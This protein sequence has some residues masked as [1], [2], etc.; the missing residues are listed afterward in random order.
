MTNIHGTNRVIEQAK[1]RRAD[2]IG[3]TIEAYAVPTALVVGLT[4]ML[5]QFGGAP[6]VD[7]I[8]HGAPVAQVTS[9][10]R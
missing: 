1:T 6:P 9:A 3:S 10:E 5:L 4:L 8:E 7:T 2:F